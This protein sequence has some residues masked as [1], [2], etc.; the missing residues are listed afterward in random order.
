MGRPAND[1]AELYR[2]HASVCKV[3]TDPK[4]LMILDVL[5]AGD[6]SVGE[7]ADRLGIALPNASQHLAVLRGAG[8]VDGRRSG[9]TVVY[10]LAEPAI[11]D[12]CDVIHSIVERRV[13]ERERRVG[14]AGPR[15]SMDI[16]ATAAGL[17]VGQGTQR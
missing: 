14:Q 5:R 12:A 1:D 7:I 10:R 13:V 6:L 8:L 4:R 17:P 2:L 9:T 11:V 15:A 16:A 3:L